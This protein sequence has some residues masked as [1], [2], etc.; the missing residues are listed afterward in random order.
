MQSPDLPHCPRR[1]LTLGVQLRPPSRPPTSLSSRGLHAHF[2]A[3]WPACLSLTAAC[4]APSGGQLPRQ[5]ACN[6]VG[7]EPQTAGGRPRAMQRSRP[8]RGRPPS[9]AARARP[10]SPA[11]RHR[12][13]HDGR[14]SA[15]AGSQGMRSVNASPP[16]YTTCTNGRK[17]GNSRRG[18]RWRRVASFCMAGFLWWPA[19]ALR[20]RGLAGHRPSPRCRAAVPK[21]TAAGRPATRHRWHARR[22]PARGRPHRWRSER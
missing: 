17:A 5:A 9:S 12:Q 10:A 20:C 13:G 1:A 2:S 15:C 3:I 7:N 21:A 14:G 22:C 6:R 19:A 18:A 11:C 16:P 4:P 8:A